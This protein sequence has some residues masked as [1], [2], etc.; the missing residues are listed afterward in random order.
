M[1]ILLIAWRNVW[2]NPT[3]SLVI[4]TAT[5][6]GL[7]VGVYSTALFKG[8][9]EMR[10]QAGIETEVGHLQIHRPGFT[11]NYD[12]NLF[13]DNTDSLER[14]LAATEGME[15]FSG[16]YV[17]NAMVSS[18][19]NGLGVRV[20]GIQAETEKKVRN[21]YK[22]VIQGE[23]LGEEGKNPVLIGDKLARKLGVR[24]KSKIILTFQDTAGN[25]IRSAFRVKGIY[26]T[27]SDMYDEIGR[28]HV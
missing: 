3:R 8:M 25:I 16:R 19:E 21:L 1:K 26:R 23:Y 15:G 7:M 9:S 6:L 22:K 13:M 28:A 14:M 27:D 17:L 11:V 24:L 20:T 12:P 2:R 4:I 18:A 5:G 10:I